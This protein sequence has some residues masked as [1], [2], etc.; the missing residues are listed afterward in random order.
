MNFML[1]AVTYAMSLQSFG[2]FPPMFL[3]FSAFSEAFFS[4]IVK[5]AELSRNQH[6]SYIPSELH[7]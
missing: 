7:G 3:L 1:C 4:E 2:E 5:G 6:R